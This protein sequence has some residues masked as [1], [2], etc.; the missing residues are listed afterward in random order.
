MSCEHAEMRA[1]RSLIPLGRQRPYTVDVC[2][3]MWTKPVAF[4]EFH[5]IRSVHDEQDWPENRPL[6]NSTNDRCCGRLLD[7]VYSVGSECS[8]IDLSNNNDK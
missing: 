3:K 4:D 8:L 5:Q 1:A 7:S 2:E 6:R